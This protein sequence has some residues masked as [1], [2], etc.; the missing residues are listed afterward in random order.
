MG[1]SS[2][3]L[4]LDITATS[5]VAEVAKARSEVSALG[6]A[7]RKVTEQSAAG[8]ALATQRR[9]VFN[10]V[11][12]ETGGNMI[13]AGK[14][15]KIF[16]E[17]Q[18]AT[19]TTTVAWTAAMQRQRMAM[20]AAEEGAYRL[21]A[22]LERD[23]RRMA[24]LEIEAY[25]M[26][27]ALSRGS[28]GGLTGS[29]GSLQSK[30]NTA[31][32]AVLFAFESFARGA[33]AAE[34]PARAALRSISMLALALG[35][36]VGIPIAGAAALGDALFEMW[37]RS[38]KAARA[39]QLQFE[40]TLE[41]ISRGTLE[42][43]A[44]AQQFAFSGDPFARRGAHPELSDLQFLALSGGQT[45]LER[46]AAQVAAQIAALRRQGI[47]EGVAVGPGE[48][49][50]GAITPEQ[51]RLERLLGQQAELNKLLATQ[52][53]IVAEIS[54]ATT[55]LTR[56]EQERARF[57][58]QQLREQQALRDRRRTA[59]EE[60]PLSIG[61]LADLERAFGITDRSRTAALGIRGVSS[62]D[63]DRAAREQRNRV[64][65][66][67]LGRIR[68][69]EIIQ[70]PFHLLQVETEKQIEDLA[71]RTQNHLGSSLARALATG[72]TAGFSG[73]GVTGAFH[74]AGRT[75][76]AGLGGIFIDL[77]QTYLEYSGIM[78]ALTPLL[79]NPFTAGFA[80]AAIGAAL[81]GLGAALEGVGQ[82]ARSGAGGYAASGNTFTPSAAAAGGGTT[83][84]VQTVNPWSRE[85]VSATTYYINRAG[86]LNTPVI[87]P[88]GAPT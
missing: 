79:G 46:R 44:Q 25:K 63:L 24:L 87:A 5:N 41:T 73:G 32:I 61:D 80:G 39:A 60:V 86:I 64:D 49:V 52:K 40:K 67:A 2:E 58:L 34:G 7:A 36:E 27:A 84:I 3:R 11:L 55:A 77:G 10:K 23:Q 14:A 13:A 82:R 35:P 8:D 50:A 37:N 21:D 45:G 26:D 71:Q 66:S 48:G 1:A 18:K 78:E 4:A 9:E 22:A 19:S 20:A 15:V 51:K 72:I 54:G 85:V 83:L 70:T 43:A 65:T 12:T 30:A 69:A 81:I 42:Q 16:D 29:F 62:L 57:R 47:A 56:T 53:D 75:L 33:N 31:G 6:D 76:L 59:P 74:A 38:E 88:P 17:Q 28:G 68:P